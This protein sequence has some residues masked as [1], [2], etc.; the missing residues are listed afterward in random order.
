MQRIS[1][2]VHYDFAS[3]ICYV[4]HRVMERVAPEL[5]E[6][7]VD[8]DWTP[9]DLA[10]LMGW[11]VGEPVEGPRRDNALRVASEL[12]VAVRM[13]FRWIDSRP[14]MSMALALR[15]SASELSWRERV[16]S[17]IHEEG[18]APDDEG[19]LAR[20]AADLG[21]ALEADA[22]RERAGE[23]VE[24]TREAAAGGVTSLPCFVLA[25]LPLSGIQEDATMLRMLGRYAERARASAS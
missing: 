16:W 19:E 10:A 4:A 1:I 11:P 9:L 3:T 22:L 21:L 23:L 8:L 20:L 18:R 13:P 14:A 2:P 17:A 5:D 7:G 6:L 25:G 24:R 15:G 12:G